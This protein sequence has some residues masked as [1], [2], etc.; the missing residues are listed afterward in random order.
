[1]CWSYQLSTVH[2]PE[3]NWKSIHITGHLII[4][5]LTVWSH[6]TDEMDSK[7]TSSLQTNSCRDVFFLS[8]THSCT[9]SLRMRCLPYDLFFLFFLFPWLTIPQLI[10]LRGRC[11][12][13]FCREKYSMRFLFS[14]YGI[15]F[16]WTSMGHNN[17]NA[18]HRLA[19]LVKVTKCSC[20]WLFVCCCCYFAQK[21]STKIYFFLRFL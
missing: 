20:W 14:G 2:V 4:G 13:V 7:D 18:I 6:T 15:Y 8:H 10:D 9:H 12:D 16:D 1:M 5:D 19:K 11:F 3:I 21:L 17:V